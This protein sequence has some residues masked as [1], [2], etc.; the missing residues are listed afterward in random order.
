MK[1]FEQLCFRFSALAEA[2]NPD[3]ADRRHDIPRIAELRSAAEDVMCRAAKLLYDNPGAAASALDAALRSCVSAWLLRW[4]VV[5]DSRDDALLA[6][7]RHAPL[8]ALRVEW[9][10]GRQDP[11][12]RLRGC[13]G[14][15]RAVFGREPLGVDPVEHRLAQPIAHAA[16]SRSEQNGNDSHHQ[17]V[18]FELS[19]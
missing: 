14:V 1:A 12:D 2:E 3:D 6:L 17:P 13:V 15:F 16:P 10:L 19:H 5:L 7:E 18:P 11:R 4:H 8:L 9:A